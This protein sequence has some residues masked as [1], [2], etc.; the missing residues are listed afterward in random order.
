MDRIFLKTS[1]SL[2]I[3]F[4][5][6]V[7]CDG[8]WR[9]MVTVDDWHNAEHDAKAAHTYRKAIKEAHTALNERNDIDTARRILSVA[10]G[11]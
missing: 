10:L 9:Y 3:Y 11:H 8:I 1:P 5:P 2:G 6:K 7:M 4:P